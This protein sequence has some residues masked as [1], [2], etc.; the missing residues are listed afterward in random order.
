MRLALLLLVGCTRTVVEL[1][2]DAPPSKPPDQRGPFDP[3]PPPP[4][5]APTLCDTARDHSDFAWIETNVFE[6]SC[7]LVGCHTGAGAQVDLRLDRGY[8]YDSLVGRASSTQ[9]DWLR[10]T[11]GTVETSYLVV[12]L[13][14]ALGPPPRDG[15][16]PL[17]APVLCDEIQQAIER[18]IALGAH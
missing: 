16:M 2:L 8:A 12:A 7:A 3:G 9:P 11:P 15:W 5:A 13:G 4:D 14:R 6:R 18:W 17:G 10:V 1:D